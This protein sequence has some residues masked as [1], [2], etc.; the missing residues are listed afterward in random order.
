IR[1]AQ[2]LSD[3]GIREINLVAQDTTRY[4]G[5]AD[6]LKKL[7]RIDDLHWIRL[8]YGH[9]LNL[10][11]DVI[12]L[13]A[14][15]EKLCS[16]IDVP[17]QHIADPVLKRMGR[18]ITRAR[19]EKLIADLQKNNIAIRT[20]FIVGFPGETEQDFS[21]LL[22]F[23]QSAHFEHLGTFA[24]RDEEGTP[25]ARMGTKVPEEIKQERYDRLMTLQAGIA[26][27]KN[28][29]R[30]GNSYEVLVDGIS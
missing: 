21:E 6:L 7:A 20:T 25:A 23:V 2:K 24:Y 19:T 5:L 27:E 11:P 29:A 10:G 30:I 28:R 14:A 3:A 12:A 18:R 1:E 15:E 8:L 13:L 9:P 4:E 16:Y 26:A 22:S 17:L